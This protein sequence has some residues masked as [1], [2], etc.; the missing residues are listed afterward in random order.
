MLVLVLLF[1]AFTSWMLNSMQARKELKEAKIL[2]DN[3]TRSYEYTARYHKN[4]IGVSQTTEKYAREALALFNLLLEKLLVKLGNNEDARE[5]VSELSGDAK[6]IE[7]QLDD[8]HRMLGQAIVEIDPTSGVPST[9][10]PQ[11]VEK[12]T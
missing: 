8:F 10:L 9:Q 1:V 3:A 6:K 12:T 11:D 4:F 2:Y 5:L 7:I